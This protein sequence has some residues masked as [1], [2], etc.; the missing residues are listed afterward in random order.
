M[1]KKELYKM[2]IFIFGL[3]L[4]LF[5]CTSGGEKSDTN[6]V[7]EDTVENTVSMHGGKPVP[8]KWNDCG[9][10]IGDHPCDF[11]FVDQ[12]GDTFQLY[13]NYDTVMVLDFSAIWCSVCNNI[14]HDAQ[15]FMDDYG[16]SGF[17][18][19]TVL[20]DNSSGDPPEQS[21]AASWADIY[22]ITDAPVLAGDRSVVDLSAESG[23]PISAWPTLVILDKEMIITNGILG[24]NEQTIRQWV[25]AQL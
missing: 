10:Q 21:E 1:Y 11:S 25:E 23:F 8:D 4:S 7:Q 6:K 22:G 14:A 24:W 20:V 19:V 16:D 3:F 13:D 5:A 2:K 17:L 12:N 9:G 15:V 18:W